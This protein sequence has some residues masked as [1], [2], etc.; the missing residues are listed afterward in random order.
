MFPDETFRY[1]FAVH[2]VILLKKFLKLGIMYAGQQRRLVFYD[3][4]FDYTLLHFIQILS[5]KF[6][7]FD[8]L[9]NVLY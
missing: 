8:R 9:C 7:K 4:N 1:A 5:L 6:E 3:H 2:D